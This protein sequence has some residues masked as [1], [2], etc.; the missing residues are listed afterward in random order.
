MITSF[1]R[2]AI[3]NPRR[4]LRTAVLAAVAVSVLV[5]PQGAAARRVSIPFDPANFSDP[6]DIDNP[7]LP[8]V[9]GTTT[10]YRAEG[11]DGCEEARVTVTSATKVIAGVTARVVHDEAFE[12]EE[13]DGS[14]VL[15]ERTDDWFA[16][17]DA[18]NVWYLGEATEDCEGAGNCEPGPGAW[19]A[20]VAGAKAGI[21]M[22]AT[23]RPGDQ[24][25]QEIAR[26]T[27]EDQAKIIGVATTVTLT[28]DDAF[29]PGQWTNCLKTKEWTQLE[30]GH[31]E[32]KYYC[33]NIGLVAVDE[34]HGGTV[35]FELVG[36]TGALRF[37]KVPKG[38]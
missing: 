11:K 25:Y 15:V 12:D 32:H 34:L 17:D 30:P 9:V 24:Y 28:R 22:L 3:A 7:F 10:I 2:A 31:V 38:N 23:R 36:G 18:G 16:Q 21:I 27:A 6:L 35:R 4:T 29:S 26:G 37:R 5:L 1:D 20:G 19:Q 13:C 8:M 14:L 33:R